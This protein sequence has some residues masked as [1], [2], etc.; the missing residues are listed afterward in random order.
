VGSFQPEVPDEPPVDGD[1]QDSGQGTPSDSIDTA[2]AAS[3]PA[4][5]PALV[6]EPADQLDD[7][8][9]ANE[10]DPGDSADVVPEQYDQWGL[11][12]ETATLVSDV[13]GDHEATL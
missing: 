3:P 9:L 1:L 11:E 6:A 8:P 12:T 2:S 13:E 4:E 5:P 7:L 10:V